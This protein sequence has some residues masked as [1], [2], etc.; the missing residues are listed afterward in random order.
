MQLGVVGDDGL[1]DSTVRFRVSETTATEVTLTVSG[2]DAAGSRWRSDGDYR[3]DGSGELV[4]T[5]PDAPWTTMRFDDPGA[6]PTTFE[7]TDSQLDFTATVFDGTES[8][9]RT[10]RRIWGRDLASENLT[11]D[12]WELAVYRPHGH[13]GPLPAVVVLPGT[14]VSRTVTGT[15]ALLAS[16]GYV[17]AVLYY[18]QRPGLPEHFVRIRTEAIADGIA[19]L[20]A[21]SY[22]NSDA[23]AIHAASVGV[24]TALATMTKTGTKAKAVVVVAPSHVVFQ[25]LRTDGPPEKASALTHAGVDLP[26]V[27]VRADRLLPQLAVNLLRSKLF[28]GPT[29]KALATTKAYE[30]GLRDRTAVEAA[31]IPVEEIDAPILAIAGTD[32]QCYPAAAMAKEIIDRRAR[33]A[34]CPSGDDQLVI[35][36]RVGH[37]IRPPAAPTTVTRSPGLIGGGEP[38]AIAAAERDA[39]TRILG[40]LLTH[41]S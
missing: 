10:V 35:Y 16:H 22:V 6:T 2:Y 4:I 36:P 26:Y 27:P 13:S 12:G 19:A 21:L 33:D 14:M 37:F 32:D 23:I 3:L 7:A 40:F 30:G 39:W 18:T 41:L 34:H 25:S 15:A 1:V 20:S 28:R 31:T 38:A 5:D 11:G 24:Q 17:T 29:S 9:S 8:A